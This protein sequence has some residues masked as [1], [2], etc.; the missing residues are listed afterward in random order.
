MLII[1][2][3][4]GWPSG[5]CKPIIEL[6]FNPDELASRYSLNFAKEKDDLDWYKGTHFYLEDVCGPI[7]LMRHENSP[8]DGTVV[9]ID[10]KE[11][12]LNAIARIKDALKIGDCKLLWV[13]DEA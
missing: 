9:Y 5:D 13:T 3:F 8:T 1:K 6:N 10:S 7:V 11:D 4:E 2:D 12:S